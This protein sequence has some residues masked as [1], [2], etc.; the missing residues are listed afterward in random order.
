MKE[1][2]KLARISLSDFTLCGAE[3]FHKLL[4]QLEERKSSVLPA[5]YR[6]INCL[7]RRWK[8]DGKCERKSVKEITK[9]ARTLLSDFTLCEAELLTKLL[10]QLE[11]SPAR[12][13]QILNRLIHSL[14]VLLL[15]VC[16]K[17]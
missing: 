17:A 7:Y 14:F 3:L 9:L 4:K 6:F 16:L 10:K 5:L 13:F 8:H 15:A 1:I 12:F 2:T 11:E